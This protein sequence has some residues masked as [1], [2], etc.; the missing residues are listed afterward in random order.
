MLRKLLK[1]LGIL[2]GA[3]LLVIVLAAAVVYVSSES[4][5][6]KAYNANV[7]AVAIPTDAA[8][9]ERGR[10]LATAVSD[11]VG[12]HGSNLAGTVIFDDPAVGHLEAPNLTK[13]K[14]G[15][16]SALND[17]DFVRVIRHGVLPNGKSVRTMPSDDFT[18]L[19]DADLGAIIAWVKSMPPVDSNPP[20]SSIGPVGRLLIATG[21]S[22]S[23]LP[24]GS[25][26]TARHQRL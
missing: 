12:C 22:H 23:W 21:R 19:T 7:K 26:P 15:F 14:N 24:N 10:H 9:V 2:V 6:N 18:Y 8:A 3:L 20:Q 13:G 5:L 17:A 25:T 11:C 4:I 16:G 1:G